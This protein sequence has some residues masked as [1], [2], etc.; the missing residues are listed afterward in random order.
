MYHDVPV[1]VLSIFESHLKWLAERFEIISPTQ[2]VSGNSGRHRAK[3]LLTFD[4]GCQD[5]YE[6]VAPL[7]ESQGLRGL[8]FVCPGF[9][10]LSRAA[11]VELM[12]RSS[13]LLDEKTRDSRW[14]R[15][16]RQQIVDL[17]KRGHGIGNHTMT[18]VPLSR[19]DHSTMVREISR[20][21]ATLKDWLGHSCSFFAWTY[22]WNEIS[23]SALETAQACHPYCF[24]P[25]SGLNRWP[26]SQRLLWRTGIDISKPLSNLK[27]QISGIVDCM[28]SRHR[29]RLGS[30]WAATQ[31]NGFDSIAVPPQALR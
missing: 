28:Y 16:S 13:V 19:V 20:G 27:S 26:V 8:F 23:L 11:S 9:S 31:S 4:D 5:N 29:H 14:Q 15:M 25:C 30:L 21:A 17:D 10:G 12:E 2:F 1:Q 24:S 18:H 22:S 6:L 7:L 3:V